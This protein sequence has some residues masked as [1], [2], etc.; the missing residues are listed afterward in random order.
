[1]L[2]YVFW[3]WPR[4]AV[5]RN[6]YEDDLVR[7]HAALAA[8]PPPGFLGSSA[9]R[10]TGAP[11]CEQAPA[12]EDWYRVDDFAALGVLNEAAVSGSLRGPHDAV[13]ARAA[14]GAAGL[15]APVRGGELTASSVVWVGKPGGVAY[16]DFVDSLAAETVW[17]RQLVLGPTPEFVLARPTGGLVPGIR[18]EVAAVWPR[19]SA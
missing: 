6:A 10:V 8:A 19:A 1:M 13:A 15:Y 7:F 9:A 11:W 12:Y 16:P 2:A 17:Q 5:E 4:T 3:H 18:V 14:G